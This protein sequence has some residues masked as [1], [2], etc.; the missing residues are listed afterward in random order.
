MMNFFKKKK[1]QKENITEFYKN[2]LSKKSI[3]V[4][5]YWDKECKKL[6]EII[7][8]KIENK[9]Y[10][11]S[12]LPEFNK[13]KYIKITIG[14]YCFPTEVM[15]LETKEDIFGISECRTINE[16]CSFKDIVNK[17][18]KS[19]KDKYQFSEVKLYTFL[20]TDPIKRG[21]EDIFILYFRP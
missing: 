3:D 21:I 19:I 20:N 14:K 16:S 10:E 5:D 4:N 1:L 12:S 7:E 18:E 8:T 15:I 17:I 6:I 11:I 9:E 13:N 2:L